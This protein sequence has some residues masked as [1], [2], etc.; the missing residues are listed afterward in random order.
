MLEDRLLNEFPEDPQGHLRE[1]A[2]EIEARYEVRLGEPQPDR[3]P[4]VELSSV[5][6]ASQT[7]QFEGGSQK[8]LKIAL[9]LDQL[10]GKNQEK[11]AT[12]VRTELQGES[13]EWLFDEASCFHATRLDQKGLALLDA[14]MEYHEINVTGR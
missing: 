9:V 10:Y 3:E 8:T 7:Y 14:F 11:Y 1:I 12:H 2:Q 4:E 5:Q 6:N 13:K